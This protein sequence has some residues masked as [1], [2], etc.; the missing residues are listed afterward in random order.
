MV[1]VFDETMNSVR[2]GSRPRNVSPMSAPSTLETKWLRNCG[3]AKGASARVAMAGPKVGAADADVDDVGHR[4]AERAA[5]AALAHVGGEA[6]HLLARADDLG[7]DVLAVDQDRLA[8]EIAQRGMQ[9]GALLGRVDVFAGEH[10]VALGLDL[11]GLGELEE[12]A[13]D[14]GVDALLGIIEQEIVEGDAELLEP[15][16]IVGE[17]GSRRTGEHASRKPSVS[18]APPSRLGRHGLFLSPHAVK[19]T[20]S[21]PDRIHMPPL[22]NCET[23]A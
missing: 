6:Q 19:L 15:R 18:P 4:L 13:A 7:H 10:R 21:A 22:L 12:R 5:H 3:G 2:A 1:K 9:D 16:R 20:P 11:G 14:G 8:G 17:I 23:S